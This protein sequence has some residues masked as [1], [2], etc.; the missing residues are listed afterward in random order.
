MG[1]GPRVPWNERTCNNAARNGHLEVLR[2]AQAHG[3]SWDGSF[4]ESDPD[5]YSGSEYHS[6]SK[7][8]SSEDGSG[9]SGA[10]GGV[11]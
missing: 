2:W 3:C 4:P 5:E 6:S 1:A 7:E 10:L 8:N 9:P 11:P